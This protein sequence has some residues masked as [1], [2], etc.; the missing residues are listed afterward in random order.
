MM[1]REAADNL[2]LGI[3]T[4]TRYRA[5]GCGPMYQKIGPRRVFYD[6]QDL[7]AWSASR[8]GRETPQGE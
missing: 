8:T 1:T 6:R 4:L 7:D 2:R 3:P 5:G